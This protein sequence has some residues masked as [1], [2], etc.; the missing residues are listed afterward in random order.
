MLAI[1][2]NYQK[3]MKNILGTVACNVI[4]HDSHDENI[5]EPIRF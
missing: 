5:L 1:H 4:G 2:I 3:S